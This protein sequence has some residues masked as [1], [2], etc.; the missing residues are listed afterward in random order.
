VCACMYVCM[1]GGLDFNVYKKSTKCVVCSVCMCVY[2]TTC[3]MYVM[4]LYCIVL[5]VNNELVLVDEK[6][7]VFEGL[8]TNFFCAVRDEESPVGVRFVTAAAGSV[9]KGTVQAYVEKVCAQQNIP[10]E[11]AHP[12]LQ[13]L[14]EG[15][16]VGCFL[17]SSSRTVLPI[18][19]L[20]LYND[21][22]D[23]DRLNATEVFQEVHESILNLR[24]DVRQILDDE[25]KAMAA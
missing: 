9:L 21:A 7:N 8:Q 16:W 1:Y 17:T 10:I 20:Q 12:N 24:R 18:L 5:Q 13:D 15:K 23:E 25:A 19:Q 6:F 22:A 2:A 4:I 14:A 3:Y 11:Y